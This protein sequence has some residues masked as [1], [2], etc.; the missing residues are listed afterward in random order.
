MVT[1]TG[2]L[3]SAA[4]GTGV[5]GVIE[6]MLCG[7]GSWVPRVDGKAMV[8]RIQE[9]AIA[10]ASDG[11]FSFQVDPNDTI[12]PE[13]TYYTVTVKDD[14]GDIAQVN[15]Y[16]FLSFPGTYDLNSIDPF[17][18]NFPPPPLPPLNLLLI[19]P[20][21]DNMIFDGA[22]FTSFKTTLNQ[23]VTHPTIQRM[24]P[25]N[26]YTFIIQENNVG[27]WTFAWPPGVSNATL[28]DPTANGGT[29]QTFVADETG[30]LWPIGPGTY[31]A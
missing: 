15:A 10:V 28:V 29:V 9:S 27:G 18:P 25:G 30:A 21:S 12:V 7:Y 13:N 2:K 5:M 19:L 4:N 3:E 24:R 31:Y 8:A 26:L 23:N 22:T 1:V 14:N 20:P 11:T 16:R 17:N 6:V